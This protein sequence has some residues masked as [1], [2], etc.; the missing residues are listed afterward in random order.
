MKRQRKNSCFGKKRFTEAGAIGYAIKN[1]AVGKYPLYAY[2]CKYCSAWHVGTLKEKRIEYL[3]Q[4]IEK[5]R[6]V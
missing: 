1:R 6:V 5:E 4:Q 3:F 2:N